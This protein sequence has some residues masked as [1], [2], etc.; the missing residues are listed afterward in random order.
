MKRDTRDPAKLLMVQIPGRAAEGDRQ[1]Y[2]PV[3][4]ANDPINPQWAGQ[5]A[6]AFP[7]KWSIGLS[8]LHNV[9]AREHNLFVDEFRRR[10]AARPDDDSGLRDPANPKRV[11]RMKDVSNEELF[12]AA[13][14]T[15]AAEIAKIAV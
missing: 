9:F 13:R 11:I 12:Q 6:V 15:V 14:L 2:L 3:F 1:G 7:D 5:E 8:F 4:A 10:A